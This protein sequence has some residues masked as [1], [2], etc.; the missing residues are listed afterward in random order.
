MAKATERIFLPLIRLQFPEIIDINLPI[1]G[2][3]HNLAIVSIRKQYPGHAR[4][5]I[6]ALWGLGQM[7]STK[8]IIVVDEGVNVHDLHEVIWRVGNNIDPERD[9]EFSHGPLD[10]LDHASRLPGYGSKMGID[11]TKKLRGEG[12]EREWPE[13]IR[14]DSGVIAKIN[15]LWEELGL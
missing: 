12:F 5:V 9:I 13:E 15:Q 2:V 1:E 6:H 11:A 8:I 14:M 4:K 7:S 3:F 10:I